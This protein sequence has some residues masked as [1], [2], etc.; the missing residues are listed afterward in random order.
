[1]NHKRGRPKNRRSG[2]LFCKPH[3]A[4]GTKGTRNAQTPQEL[5]APSPEE[6][7]DSYGTYKDYPVQDMGGQCD[8]EKDPSIVFDLFKA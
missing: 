8:S 5:R 1:M 7:Q 4:N 2:C 3:K 6:Y